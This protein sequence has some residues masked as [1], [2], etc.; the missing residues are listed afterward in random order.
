MSRSYKKTPV[1]KEGRN[2]AG[3]KKYWKKRA[4]KK[5]RRTK[6]LGNKSNYY[7]KVY[8]SWDICDYR[9]FHEKNVDMDADEVLDWEKV[10]HRK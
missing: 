10:Y 6:E 1:L 8:E 9:F 4:H 3:S 5:E 2:K 7:R